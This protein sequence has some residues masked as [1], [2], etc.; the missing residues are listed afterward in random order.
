MGPEL[1]DEVVDLFAHGEHLDDRF[2]FGIDLVEPLVHLTQ[3][4]IHPIKTL[5]VRVVK[6][7]E[8]LHEITIIF[9]DR[10]AQAVTETG[11]AFLEFFGGKGGHSAMQIE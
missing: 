5:G 11:E 1:P 4:M 7:G 2:E 8:V 9:L 6:V 3:S 10:L